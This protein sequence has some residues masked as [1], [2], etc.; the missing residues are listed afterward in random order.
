MY[1]TTS[2]Q[3]TPRKR[4]VGV[5][6]RTLNYYYVLPNH[7]L[8]IHVLL[9]FAVLNPF[10]LPFGTLYFFV[11]S[12]VIKNQLIHVYAKNY[13][14]NGKT[15]L[16]RMVRYS[17]DGMILS[18]VVMLAYMV[19]LKKSA[20]VGLC[21]FLI[22]L[23]AVFKLMV[24]R[25]CRAQFE[26]DDIAEAEA[27]CSNPASEQR[28]SSPDIVPDYMEN[29]KSLESRSLIQT[30]TRRRAVLTWKVP[31]WINFSYSTIRQ[32]PNFHKDR[33]KP[34]PFDRDSKGPASRFST[35]QPRGAPSLI[36]E[37][38]KDGPPPQRP[39]ATPVQRSK[40]TNIGAQ[41]GSAGPV[42]PHPPP[43]PWDDHQSVDLPYDNPYY[44]REISNALWLP[45]DPVNV[46]DLDDTVDM[47]V[48]LTVDLASGQVGTWLGLLEQSSPEDI[49]I[50][51]S[52]EIYAADVSPMTLP[53]SFASLPE[54]DGTEDIDL[55]P[56]IKQRVQ[57]N[58]RG[59]EQTTRPRRSTVSHAIS[60]RSDGGTLTLLSARRRP[61]ALELQTT[62]RSV[63]D[64]AS[65]PFLRPR[66]TSAVSALH[67]GP[68]AMSSSKLSSGEQEFG[69]RPDT[70]AQAE[71]VAAMTTSKVSLAPSKMARSQNLSAQTAI[72]HE[73]L[74]EEKQAL[75]ERLQDEQVEA[76][77]KSSTK[78]WLTSWMFKRRHE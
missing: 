25:M 60:N 66:S 48:A 70:H 67:L 41:T 39:N 61:S 71:L 3:V 5:R 33:R 64:G 7:L 9:V 19:V 69:L 30:S 72:L 58:E 36:V 20:N 45:R 11:Q 14:G 21:V 27:L 35:V 73:I 47:K 44:T 28:P 59:I 31:H 13:E 34:I 6:P 18:L 55:P 29:T 57:A 50:V 43:L 63:S 38:P 15:L 65:P 2:R 4:T 26:L 1:P 49:G 46:L 54:V 32:R 10:V 42:V 74:A 24:T 77:K 22:A 8:V 76:T 17:L 68:P 62:M 12:G 23:T 52:P 78:S 51:P 75:Y 40:L 16:I 53:V 37:E 56:T